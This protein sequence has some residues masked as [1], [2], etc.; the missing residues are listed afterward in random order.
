MYPAPLHSE[1]LSDS[2]ED[3]EDNNEQIIRVYQVWKG[4]NVFLLGGR[5]ICGPDVKS[6]F[7]TLF[8]ILVP[9]ILFCAFVSQ[10]LVEEFPHFLG[11]TITTICVIWTTYVVILLL[12]TSGR[13]PGIIPRNL[14]PPDPDDYDESSISTDWARSHSGASSLPPTKTVIVNRKAVKV[15]YCRTCMLY[16]PP[17]CSHCSVCNNC[18]ERFDHHC[19]WVGQCIGRRNYRYFFMF[20]SSTTLLCLYVF[21]FS[22]ANIM[23]IS[24]TNH[25]NIWRAALMSPISGV[26]IIYTFL[27]AWFVGGLTTFHLYLICTNQTTYENFRYGYDTMNNPYNIGCTHNVWEVLLSKIPKS[28]HNFRA[29]ILQDSSF[30]TNQSSSSKQSMTPDMQITSFDFEVRKRQAISPDDMRDIRTNPTSCQLERCDTRSSSNNSW[31]HPRGDWDV[32]NQDPTSELHILPTEFEH[33]A[34]DK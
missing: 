30:V 17:R 11:I 25:C 2:S 6:L 7:L 28:K 16:R 12:M 4:S 13:D 3:I 20:V 23:V 1:H 32:I 24:T 14:H 5:L 21:S 18:V 29:Q 19:P 33:K 9:V 31:V 15:K 27:V 34:H 10:D 8:L 26:L 22:W